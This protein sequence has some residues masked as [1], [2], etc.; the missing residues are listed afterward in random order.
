MT[1][2]FTLQAMNAHVI[3]I[4]QTSL[5]GFW[6][7]AIHAKILIHFFTLTTK[8]TNTIEI[9]KNVIMSVNFG[10]FRK[11]TFSDMEEAIKS[12]RLSKLQNTRLKFNN[13]TWDNF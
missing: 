10:R 8:T 13:L 3:P 6:R 11:T 1:T 4:Q 5:F 12:V 9:M 2:E 7:S